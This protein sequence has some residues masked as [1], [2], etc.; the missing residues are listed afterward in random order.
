MK[1]LKN[2]FLAAFGLMTATQAMAQWEPN[3]PGVVHLNN[4]NA[5]KSVAIGTNVLTP[6]T[7]NGANNKLRVSLGN[8]MLDYAN[9]ATAGNLFFGAET[10]PVN[11][12]PAL[13]NGM[14]MSY[15]NGASKNGYIDVRTTAATDGLIFRVDAGPA[16]GTERMRI[17]GNGN[18]GIGVT[19]LSNYKTSINNTIVLPNSTGLYV[20]SSTPTGAANR[21][22][23]VFG[24]VTA[25]VGYTH[26]VYGSSTKTNNPGTGGRAYGVYGVASNGT[27]GYN[28]G[29]FGDLT[30]S[31]NGAAVLGY[32]RISNPAWSGNTNGKWAGYFVGNMGVT[33]RLGINNDAP[34]YRLDVVDAAVAN[35]PIAR[36][37]APS[38]NGRRM[39]FVPTLGASG[40][41]NISQANDVGIIWSDNASFNASSGFVLAPHKN[42]TAGIRL[43]IDGNTTVGAGIAKLSLGHAYLANLDF[44]TSYLGFNALLNQS[45]GVFTL[46]GDGA[47]NGGS[48]IWGDVEGK[49]RFATVPSTSGSTQM[50]AD[51]SI[52]TAT[53]M[54]IAADG[55]V[56]IGDRLTVTN[57]PGSYLLYVRNGILTE[58]VKVAIHGT[59]SWADYVF[60]EGYDLLPLEKVDAF[61]KENGHLP[62]VPSAEEI[63]EN[64][65]FELK[66]MAVK[67]QEKIEEIY[68]HL[69][70]LNK[71]VTALEAENAALKQAMQTGGK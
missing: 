50:P 35:V 8:I 3:T 29:V 69:I 64:G 22:Y 45:T 25:G 60:E 68:L 26:G 54:S 31:M 28:Y 59:A 36:F 1:I 34:A 13:S 62:N 41:N 51:L 55:K 39:F 52:R 17:S 57:T 40:W 58:Q 5:N 14:R 37:S 7:N 56:L 63:V 66:E 27:A 47:H 42:G 67:H 19:A 71:K 70:A 20:T 21:T 12:N 24:T 11:A 18:V 6:G 4:A 44:G 38:A 16:A 2:L 9:S 49:I 48:V 15:N 46:N 53:K 30:G 61:V 32:D 33:N 10:Y 65:G 23:S 43:D